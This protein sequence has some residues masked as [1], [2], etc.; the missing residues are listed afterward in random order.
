MK[1]VLSFVAGIGLTLGVVWYINHC[2]TCTSNKNK[3]AIVGQKAPDFAL[4]NHEGALITLAELTKMEKPI[5]LEWFNKDCPYTRK[6]YTPGQMQRL[7]EEFTQKGVLWVRIVSSAPGKQG[8]LDAESVQT[9][10]AASY[11]THTL[12]DPTGE[13][14]RMYRATVTPHMMVIDKSG[15]LAYRGAIDSIRSFDS[16][17]ILKAE[18]Y[19]VA[20][21]NALEK[22]TPIAVTETEEYGCS[23]KY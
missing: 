23:I 16:A 12:L 21:L 4:K 19:V 11:A 6:F 17:D 10:H 1:T 5:V 8:Y 2:A 14:G 22:G 13:V 15:T 20:A 9:Q 18:N 7:Q 3:Q